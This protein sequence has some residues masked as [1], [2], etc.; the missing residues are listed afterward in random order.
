M[1]FAEYDPELA[2]KVAIE[3]GFEDGVVK[4]RTEGQADI[5]LR[6]NRNGRSTAEIAVDTGMSQKQVEDI[7]RSIHS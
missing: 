3:E 4:G 5:I 6:M 1:L 7:L 2:R